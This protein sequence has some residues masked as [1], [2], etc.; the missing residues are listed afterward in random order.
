[1][2][3]KIV[4]KNIKK[5]KDT[6]KLIT[7]DNHTYVIDLHKPPDVFINPF[8]MTNIT[9]LD[10]GIEMYIIIKE[11]IVHQIRLLNKNITRPIYEFKLTEDCISEGI[12]SPY[13]WTK[14][15]ERIWY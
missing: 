9:K 2:Q 13:S 1:M 5:L 7:E 6:W 11:N 10:E 15:S 4:A 14:L 12:H 8:K 3:Y